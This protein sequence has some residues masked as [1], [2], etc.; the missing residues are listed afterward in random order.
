[1]G[2]LMILCGQQVANWKAPSFRAAYCFHLNDLRVGHYRI[3]MRDEAVP[4][5]YPSTWRTWRTTGRLVI[6]L[7]SFD[8][9]LP[10][11]PCLVEK[12]LW[13]RRIIPFLDTPLKTNIHINIQ[14]TSK[15]FQNH[16]CSFLHVHCFFSMVLYRN[17]R[18]QNHRKKIRSNFSHFPWY[19]NPPLRIFWPSK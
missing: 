9:H 14:N 8:A 4:K 2:H 10:S 11:A 7:P 6:I 3:N 5:I 1:M 16:W 19:W 13:Y 15:I 12:L 17:F 18:D